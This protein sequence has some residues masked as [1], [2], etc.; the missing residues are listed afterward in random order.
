MKKA[1]NYFLVLF[2]M[3]A[4][5][6]DAQNPVPSSPQKNSVLI[7][8]VKAHIGNGK[9]IENAA[10]GFE[11]G[12]LTLVA[13]ATAIRLQQ[14][15]YKEIIDGLGR[16]AYPGL[17]A[18]NTHL[19]LTEIDLVRATIDDNEVGD[20]NSNVRSI[21]SYNTDS[22]IIPTVRS[23]GVLLAEVTPRGGLVSG[24]SSVVQ[25]DAWNWEDAAVRKEIG[26]HINWP[27]MYVSQGGGPEAEENQRNRMQRELFA[28]EQVFDEASAYCKQAKPSEK[29]LKFEA[30]RGLFN[31]SQKLFVHCGY[32]KEIEA[33]VLFSKKHDFKMV[34]VGGSDAW[35]VTSLLKDNG[36]PVI[37]G[38]THALPPRDD[39]DTDLPYKLPS[40]LLKAGVKCAISID[41]SWQ[42]RNLPFMAGT[43]SAFGVPYEDAVAM[44]S[45]VP[46]EILGISDLC[47]TL[48]VGKDATL[49]LCT[50]DLLD[51]RSS[52]VEMA[53]IQGRKTDL[54]DVQ[55]QL[56]RKYSEKYGQK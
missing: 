56:Y 21:I 46:A 29:N 25:L 15:A 37:L 39:D 1:Y 38:Q 7:M 51:M 48:E 18:C 27:R 14:G 35:R 42:V 47:G 55:K 22:K 26:L 23:N 13:D 20:L 53:Y 45:S 16:H 11:N 19:G 41:G 6:V 3:F 36:V 34:L 2:S 10:I 32:V 8:N 44:V 12:K 4:G 43:A 54:D 24:S 28:L 50:G 49:V 52:V 33:A 30:M 31:G 9:V 40:M 5:A 17:V